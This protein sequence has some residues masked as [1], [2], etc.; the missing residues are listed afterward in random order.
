MT[1][2][3]DRTRRVGTVLPLVW[4]ELQW[5]ELRPVAVRTISPTKLRQPKM[6]PLTSFAC[7]CTDS[8]PGLENHVDRRFRGATDL[9]EAACLDYLGQFCLSGLG[10]QRHTHLLR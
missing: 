8:R 3:C 7:R 5:V 2:R 6:V 10:A 9:T 1:C 4:P